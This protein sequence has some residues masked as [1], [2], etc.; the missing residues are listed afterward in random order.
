MTASRLSRT[1]PSSASGDVP[2]SSACGQQAGELRHRQRL[3]VAPGR[4]AEAVM[5][6]RGAV[7]EVGDHVATGQRQDHAGG[8]ERRRAA[9]PEVAVQQRR[10]GR[11]GG[12]DVGRP[13][14]YVK[15]P[16]RS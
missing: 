13:S 3:A 1:R 9:F 11:I 7:R 4:A 15:Q 2:G 5:E 12:G 8:V 16:P 10:R 14:S 6:E